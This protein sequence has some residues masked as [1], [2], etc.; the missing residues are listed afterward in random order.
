MLPLYAQLNV[1]RIQELYYYNLGLLVFDYFNKVTFPDLLK[2]MFDNFRT[3]NP[4]FTRSKNMNLSYNVPN[5]I[6]TYR[7]PSIA[8]SMFWNSLPNEIKCLESRNTFKLK[9]K[10]YLISNY[11]S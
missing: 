1:L 3:E 7:K 8:G 11:T 2:E 5:N 10:N 6:S 4:R 9:L